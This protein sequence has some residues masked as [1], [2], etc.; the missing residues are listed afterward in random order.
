MSEKISRGS[1]LF[2]SLPGAGIMAL[3]CGMISGLP[4]SD[5]YI[6]R[7]KGKKKLIATSDYAC[8]IG[9]CIFE[10]SLLDDLHKY[11]SS[12]GVNVTGPKFPFPANGPWI[13]LASDSEG[14]VYEADLRNFLKIQDKKDNE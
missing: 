12:I 14:R 11:L 10:K 8:N 13:I 6:S 1:F 7:S 5:T 4:F 3:G 2:T 9:Q